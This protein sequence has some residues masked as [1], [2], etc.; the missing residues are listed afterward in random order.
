MEHN[1]TKLMEEE[2]E[3]EKN[4]S[5]AVPLNLLDPLEF[6][7]IFNWYMFFIVNAN[8][9]KIFFFLKYQILY[10]IVSIGYASC[11]NHYPAEY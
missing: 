1:Y 9:H 5:T 3:R 8:L 4:R 2:L 6:D 10:L 11:R 7:F